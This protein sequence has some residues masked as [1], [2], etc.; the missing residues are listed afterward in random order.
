MQDEGRHAEAV[1]FYELAIE[2]EP[3]FFLPYARIIK[4]L[5]AL[6]STAMEYWLRLGIEQLPTSVE[7]GFR[8]ALLLFYEGRYEELNEATFIRNLKLE[9]ARTDLPPDTPLGDAT[10]LQDAQ[11]MYL[12]SRAITT[13][14][15]ADAR[16]LLDTLLQARISPETCQLAKLALGPAVRLGDLKAIG[17]CWNRI[18]PECLTTMASHGTS[19]DTILARAH[20]SAG[21]YELAVVHGEQALA[22]HE[23]DE[24]SLAILWYALDE[25]DRIEEAIVRARHLYQM[26]PD[27]EDLSYNL[28]WLYKRAGRFPSAAH[29]YDDQLSR[30]ED[31]FHAA[32][33]SAFMHLLC[34]ELEQAKESWSKF[35]AI[36]EP[37]LTAGEGAEREKSLEILLAKR[38]AWKE[39]LERATNDSA[40]D[41]RLGDLVALAEGR[42]CGHT[43]FPPRPL[44]T[45]ELFRS[46]QSPE[47]IE[48]KEAMFTLQLQNRG[49]SSIFIAQ[50]KKELPRWSD[51]PPSAQR[52]MLEAQ[53]R[54]ASEETAH[55]FAPYVLALGKSVEITMRS[56]VF[57]PFRAQGPLDGVVREQLEHGA[58]DDLEQLKRFT[59]FLSKGSHLELGGMEHALR[60]L[61]GRTAR[62]FL[63]LQRMSARCQGHFPISDNYT[64][65][66]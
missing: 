23:H 40:P 52:S 54:L 13:E 48:R 30:R 46:L 17:Q 31:H 36:L 64:D 15:N 56:I 34:D 20:F 27:H 61:T 28:G 66:F 33:G 6:G 18:C 44:S 38:I 49:D 42:I 24:A 9:A 50:I 55:D 45:L 37:G 51:L 14:S 5:E 65:P 60:L 8:F 7:L 32:E 62:R 11:L 22:E 21:R 47:S 29:F 26:N 41:S 57:E 19:L 3:D 35:E 16:V 63:L 59:A 53:Q 39:L 25:L 12:A 4:S 58:P 10:H 43:G 2:E 1:N